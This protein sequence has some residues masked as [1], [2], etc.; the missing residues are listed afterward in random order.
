MPPPAGVRIEFD[1]IDEQWWTYTTQQDDETPKMIARKCASQLDEQD[2]QKFVDEV[3]DANR[4]RHPGIKSNSRLKIA[5]CLK[6]APVEENLLCSTCKHDEFPGQP[7]ICCE[8]RCSRGY[9]PQCLGLD[10]EPD[11]PWRCNHCS[12]ADVQGADAQG[13]DVQDADAHSDAGGAAAAA[14]PM[15]STESNEP[16]GRADWFGV[17]TERTGRDGLKYRVVGRFEGPDTNRKWVLCWS[18]LPDALQPSPDAS[19]GIDPSYQPPKK[20]H[21]GV[22]LHLNM[23]YHSGY[24]GVVYAPRHVLATDPNKPYQAYHKKHLGFFRT[25]EDAA[26]EV[27]RARAR[28]ETARRPKRQ[29]QE[30][31][32]A[33]QEPTTAA[34]EPATAEAAEAPAAPAAPAAAEEE[35]MAADKGPTA[36]D[37]GAVVGEEVPHT[38]EIKCVGPAATEQPEA[39]GAAKP[40]WL[41]TALLT[42]RN[43]KISTGRVAEAIRHAAG[44][45]RVQSEELLCL[46]EDEHGLDMQRVLDLLQEFGGLPT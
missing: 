44:G 2:L 14:G 43:G 33:A 12:D 28:P 21:Q 24:A 36:A 11:G 10:K 39:V 31:T 30:P 5:T 22:E 41:P 16:A 13:A 38:P 29:R 34:Q 18:K 40:A 32:T 26:A 6:F 15:P 3:V 35:H 46:L 4:K 19:P 1:D 45:V 27:A 8:G 25:T 17:G 23:R 20:C 9:H 42:L 7:I 37:R